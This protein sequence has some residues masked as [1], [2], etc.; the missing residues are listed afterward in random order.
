VRHQREGKADLRVT[1]WHSHWRRVWR[2]PVNSPMGDTARRLRL[3]QHSAVAR[4]EGTRYRPPEF[5]P[6]Y[7]VDMSASPIPKLSVEEYLALDRVAEVRSEYHDGE[8]FPVIAVTWEHGR[9]AANT[10]RRISERLDGRPCRVANSTVRIRVGATKFVYPDILVICGKPVFAD[11]EQ[12]TITNPNVIVEIL[13]PSTAGYD[14]GEKFALYRRL[15][16]FEEYILIAQDQ[17][18]IEVFRKMPDSRWIL[19]SYEGLENTV[20][21]ESLELDL[22]LAE[23]YFEAAP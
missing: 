7:N 10:I 14:Y 2:I 1:A 15:P 16:S 4:V 21:V 9:I 11:E 17:P 23:I 12:D 3:A 13:S 6:S 22:P 19:T 8:L 5:T 18:R 20:R